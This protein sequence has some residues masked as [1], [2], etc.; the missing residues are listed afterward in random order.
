MVGAGLGVALLPELS[1]GDD[2]PVAR[3]AVTNPEITRDLGLI[4][5]KGEASSAA[6]AE[7]IA[8]LRLA[9]A[10]PPRAHRPA[11]ARKSPTA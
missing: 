2:V 7:F 1:L 9:F 4:Q 6:A 8:A 3:V 5:R 11:F 10:K